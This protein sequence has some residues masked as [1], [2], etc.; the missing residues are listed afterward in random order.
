MPKKLAKVADKSLFRVVNADGLDDGQRFSNKV[1]AKKHRDELN[2]S[3]VGWYVATAVD[4][5]RYNG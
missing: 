5:W 3:K 2:A 1:A 4:H